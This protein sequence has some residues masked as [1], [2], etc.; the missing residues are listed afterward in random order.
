ML[1]DYGGRRILITIY[2]Q[3]IILQF[4]SI[5]NFAKSHSS[6]I[7]LHSFWNTCHYFNV[8]FHNNHNKKSD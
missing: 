8:S 4:L 5:S 7:I 1:R 3:K 2:V 6:F